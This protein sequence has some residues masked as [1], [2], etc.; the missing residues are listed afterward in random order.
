MTVSASIDNE[1]DSAL[2]AATKAMDWPR[3]D[4]FYMVKLTKRQM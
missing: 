4:E 1:E 3:V 2:T